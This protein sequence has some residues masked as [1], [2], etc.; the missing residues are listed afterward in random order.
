MLILRVQN[1]I[2]NF[3][4]NIDNSNASGINKINNGN[5]NIN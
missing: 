1:M 5:N 4:Y 2:A 3:L